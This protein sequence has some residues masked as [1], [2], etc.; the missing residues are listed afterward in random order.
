MNKDQIKG[1]FEKIKGEVKERIGGATKD[2]K[3]QA[4]GFV[5]KEKGKAQEKI[6]ELKRD[7]EKHEQPE[8]KEPEEP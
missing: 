6:G 4:E 1:K 7:L 8:R 2:L 3:T 5:E